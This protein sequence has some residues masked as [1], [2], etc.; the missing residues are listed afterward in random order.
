MLISPL[1]LLITLIWWCRWQQSSH[2][3]CLPWIE[4][5]T[6]DPVSHFTHHTFHTLKTWNV[7]QDIS[8][9]S[10][11]F[12]AAVAPC[13]VVSLNK[14]HKSENF[15]FCQHWPFKYS[16]LDIWRVKYVVWWSR[17]HVYFLLFLPWFISRKH[18]HYLSYVGTETT[19]LLLWVILEIRDLL[20]ALNWRCRD[21]FVLGKPGSL[22]MLKVQL[23]SAG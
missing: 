3:T 12:G 6:P 2:T 8:H 1:L 7:T 10:F 21:Y 4:L 14:G 20:K 11:A 23:L 9:N 16:R 13:Q 18:R 15:S 5:E 22:L 19:P 17:S